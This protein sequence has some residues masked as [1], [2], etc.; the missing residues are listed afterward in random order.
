MEEKKR[1]E[2]IDSDESDSEEEID[3]SAKGIICIIFKN[4]TFSVAGKLEWSKKKL[5]RKI[6]RNGDEFEEKINKK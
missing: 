2:I 4:E 5:K 6:E 3:D 1:E